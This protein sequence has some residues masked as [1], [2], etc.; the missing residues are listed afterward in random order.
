ML[1]RALPLRNK[2]TGAI[3]KWF[4][5]CTDIHEGVESRFAAKRMASISLLNLE[6][7]KADGV[8]S[9]NNSCPS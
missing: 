5:T 7:T 3:E 1:G 9:A 8:S 2:Q 6:E 4:G